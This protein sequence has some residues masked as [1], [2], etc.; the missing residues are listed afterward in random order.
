MNLKR[1][2]HITQPDSLEKREPQPCLCG[3][4][5]DRRAAFAFLRSF[6]AASMVKQEGLCEKYYDLY[7][8]KKDQTP[9]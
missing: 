9:W 5:D 4:N 3:S 1:A 2:Y 7:K 8:A 6:L